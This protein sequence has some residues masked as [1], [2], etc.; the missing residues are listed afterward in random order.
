MAKIPRIYGKFRRP[1]QVS[2]NCRKGLHGACF[3]LHCTCPCEHIPAPTRSP[4]LRDKLG[5]PN[6]RLYVPIGP[7]LTPA[8]VGLDGAGLFDPANPAANSLPNEHLTDGQD[9]GKIAPQFGSGS[10]KKETH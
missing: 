2:G 6:N 3:N 9:S 1:Y 5:R 4:E 8:E 10:P 7:E